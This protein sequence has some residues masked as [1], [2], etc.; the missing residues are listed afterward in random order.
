MASKPEN[1]QTSE[2]LIAEIARLQSELGIEKQLRSESEAQAHAMASSS[3]FSQHTAE[4]Y[5]TGRTITVK[6]CLNKTEKDPKKAKFG[7]VEY[8]TYY[9]AINIPAGVGTCITTNGIDYCHGQTYEFTAAELGDMKS[10]VARCWE[11]EKSIHGENENS[12][13]K[14]THVHIKSPAAIRKGL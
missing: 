12:Y 7:N 8:P 4:E 5:P 6:E 2:E 1:Q 10:R 9:Y 13:R 3:P 11:H 14:P